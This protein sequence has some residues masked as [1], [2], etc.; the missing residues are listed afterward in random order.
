MRFLS[1]SWAGQ[2]KGEVEV[3]L[4]TDAEDDESGEVVEWVDEVDAR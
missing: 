3:E 4:L 2:L 1:P